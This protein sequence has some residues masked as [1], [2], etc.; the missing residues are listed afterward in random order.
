[1]PELTV[2]DQR[3]LVHSGN[4]ICLLYL[5][6]SFAGKPIVTTLRGPSGRNMLEESPPDH[7]HHHGIWWGH[8]DVDG[9]DFYLEV[10]HDGM[11]RGRIEHLAFDEV[12]D[13]D[14]TFGFTE[15]LAWVSPEGETLIT[16]TRR[17]TATFDDFVPTVDLDSSYTATRDL[18]LGDTL[19]SV[20][21]GLRLAEALTEW[22]G[23]TLVGSH[24]GRHEAEVMG[25]PAEWVDYHGER[26]GAYGIGTVVEGIAVMSHPSNPDHPPKFFARGYGPLCPHQGN[27]FLGPETMASGATLRLRHRLLVHRGDEVEADIAEHY[28]LYCEDAPILVRGG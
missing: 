25:V 27:H 20:L 6:R 15:S 2:D 3:F 1:M 7:V 11:R 12:V 5:P 4:G 14:P 8:G 10:Q 22:R 18:R 26:V 28:R 9:V 19:E 23:G 13:A 21:P 17:L 16:E 24:G